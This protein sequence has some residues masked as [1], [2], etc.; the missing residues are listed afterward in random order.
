[1]KNLI[2]LDVE[3][4]GLYGLPFAAAIVGEGEEIL[5]AAK[6]KDPAIQDSWV[7]KHIVPTMRRWKGFEVYP[8]RGAMH[9]AAGEILSEHQYVLTH[10]G[11]PVE[12]NFLRECA[13]WRANPMQM[14]LMLDIAP[15]LL[16][17][18]HDPWS[19]DKFVTESIGLPPGNAHN[20]IFDA[21]V[22]RL[23]WDILTATGEKT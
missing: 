23:A 22:T 5:F 10:C 2:A 9:R 16:A 7:K 13:K 1:M 3:T 6:I 18:G 17:E 14:P 20:P 19:Q 12:A 8:D 15:L 11:A 21:R 4:D